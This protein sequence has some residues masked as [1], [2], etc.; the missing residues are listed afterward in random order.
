MLQL[1]WQRCGQG[2]Q[3]PLGALLLG[4]GLGLGWLLLLLLLPSCLRQRPWQPQLQP[5]AQLLPL[6]LQ[7]LQREA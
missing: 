6:D 1:R 2:W 4:L 3:A 5:R 7:Q